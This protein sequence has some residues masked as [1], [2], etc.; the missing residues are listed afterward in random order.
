MSQQCV[1]LRTTFFLGWRRQVVAGGRL[2]TTL[3]PLP[4][5]VVLFVRAGTRGISGRKRNHPRGSGFHVASDACVR[6]PSA[7]SGHVA[8]RRG[9]PI[10]QRRRGRLAHGHVLVVVEFVAFLVIFETGQS[11]GE[12]A[13]QRSPGLSFSWARCIVKIAAWQR[14]VVTYHV[15][16][17]GSQQ[18]RANASQGGTDFG[19]ALVVPRAFGGRCSPGCGD[20]A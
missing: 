4:F 6:P 3:A 11:A 2:A 15:A 12:R 18:K 7:V 9:L 17:W 20:S 5:C 19:T 8:G 16:S 13:P 10:S 1:H 14:A